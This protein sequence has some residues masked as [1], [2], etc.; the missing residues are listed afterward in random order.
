MSPN[1]V[2]VPRCTFEVEK[3]QGGHEDRLHLHRHHRLRHDAEPLPDD[4]RRHVQ[5]VLTMNGMVVCT[6]NLTMGLCKCEMTEDGCLVTCMSGDK[7]CCDMIQGCCDCISACLA[8][9]CTCCLM[10]NNTLVCCGCC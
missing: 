2:M 7:K 9:C 6:C 10:M 8:S 3:C 5:H 1:M 4:G